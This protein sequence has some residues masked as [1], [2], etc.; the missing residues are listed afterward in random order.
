MGEAYPTIQQ[1]SWQLEANKTRIRTDIAIMMMGTKLN[2]QVI[3]KIL[4]P[5]WEH[6]KQIPP[7]HGPGSAQEDGAQVSTRT[8]PVSL[9]HCQWQGTTRRA[10]AT[11]ARWAR[12]G[13][14]GSV[15]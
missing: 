6:A 9:R 4:Q 10:D 7:A 14:R 3:I 11:T 5:Q 2:A 13:G 12:G 1:R 8:G 15:Y